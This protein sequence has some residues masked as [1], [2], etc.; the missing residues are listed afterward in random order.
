[1]ATGHDVKDE[2]KFS[3]LGPSFL[4]PSFEQPSFNLLDS[5]LLQEPTDDPVKDEVPTE[6]SEKPSDNSQDS[7]KPEPTAAT[8]DAKA[9]EVNKQREM[10]L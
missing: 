10:L 6:V 3:F 4:G 9:L 1:M 5:L 7:S 2:V 8:F